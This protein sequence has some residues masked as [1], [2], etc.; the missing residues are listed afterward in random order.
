M[1]Q[2]FDPVHDWSSGDQQR[3]ASDEPGRKMPI[4]P[5][6]R[7]T[8]VMTLVDNDQPSSISGDLA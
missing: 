5:G 1:G 6:V 2:I 4:S 8:K 7:I 3:W